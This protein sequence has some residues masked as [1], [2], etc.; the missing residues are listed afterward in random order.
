MSDNMDKKFIDY[1]KSYEPKGENSS[2]A[3]VLLLFAES[4]MKAMRVYCTYDDSDDALGVCENLSHIAE[5]FMYP[6][7][8]CSHLFI[9]NDKEGAESGEGSERSEG[10]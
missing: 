4:I 1:V 7:V 6:L 5:M 10:T 9:K 8:N 2:Q 3:G